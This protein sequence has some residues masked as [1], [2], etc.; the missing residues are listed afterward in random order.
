MRRGCPPR[1]R[2]SSRLQHLRGLCLRHALMFTTT[3]VTTTALAQDLRQLVQRLAGT[4]PRRPQSISTRSIRTRSRK[5]CS[6]VSTS[7][8]SRGAGSDGDIANDR[9]SD[10]TSCSFNTLQTVSNTRSQP[11][12][13]DTHPYA[14]AR[15]SLWLSVGMLRL[16]EGRRRRRGIDGAD[17]CR[18]IARVARHDDDDDDCGDD[19]GA[20]ANHTGSADDRRLRGGSGLLLRRAGG[21]GLRVRRHSRRIRRS[22]RSCQ[23]CQAERPEARLPKPTGRTW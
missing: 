1:L 3:D 12:R 9:R 11:P 22:G 13:H 2:R 4:V 18:D 20:G 7:S 6:H 19:S 17:D 5:N 10:S 8:L 15:G 23:T 16:W 21:T 14:V